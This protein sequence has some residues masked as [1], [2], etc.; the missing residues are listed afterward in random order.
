MPESLLPSVGA[1]EELK[2]R[3]REKRDEVG[4]VCCFD[5]LSLLSVA[6]LVCDCVCICV[7]RARFELEFW[8][9]KA[10]NLDQEEGSDVE[11]DEE[12]EEEEDDDDDDDDDNA[13][14]N[15]FVRDAPCQTLSVSSSV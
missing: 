10:N 14:E 12:E 6:T 7:G 1:F 8:E 9:E 3:L 11:E 13:L 15:R 5:R 2:R 4:W